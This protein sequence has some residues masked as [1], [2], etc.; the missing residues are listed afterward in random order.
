MDL[1]SVARKY[2]AE[3]TQLC[4][5][6]GKP[7]LVGPFIAKHISIENARRALLNARA[8]EDEALEICSTP[9]P[10]GSSTTKKLWEDE[11]AVK[12]IYQRHAQGMGGQR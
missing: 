10:P 2:F 6:A 3:M 7:H 1:D 5:L 4:Q 9:P 11:A 8:A 12:D